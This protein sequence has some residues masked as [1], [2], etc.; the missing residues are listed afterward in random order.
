MSAICS[1][2]QNSEIWDSL[3]DAISNSSGF[4]RWQEETNLEAEFEEESLDDKVRVRFVL[5]KV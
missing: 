4:Q 2:D 1:H 5:A 3:R